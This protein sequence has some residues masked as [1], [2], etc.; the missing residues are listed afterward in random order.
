MAQNLKFKDWGSY[1]STQDNQYF[2]GYVQGYLFDKSVDK[3]LDLAGRTFSRILIDSNTEVHLES[4][5]KVFLQEGYQLSFMVDVQGGK[6]HLEL[7][8]DGIVVD[9]LDLDTSWTPLSD[10]T[11][12]YE[13]N[14]GYAKNIVSIAVHFKNI[15]GDSALVDGIW[16]I[17]DSPVCA[18]SFKEWG[19]Y[20]ASPLKFGSDFLGYTQGFLFNKSKDKKPINTIWHYILF[21]SASK[22]SVAIGGS[23]ILQEG[24]YLNVRSIDCET[25][26]VYLELTCH[27]QA[28]DGKTVSP[29]KPGATLSD[30]TYYF[31][32]NLGSAKSIVTIAVHFDKCNAGSVLVD[33]IWQISCGAI[34]PP[35]KHMTS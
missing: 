2:T 32:R 20:S 29:S 8:Q 31:K 4:G 25:G 1:S 22:Q 30:R 24:Y 28:L 33:G 27:G 11:Y 6:I 15:Y 5:Q 34:R 26:R 3:E 12:C 19:L 7:V 16:Q 13:Q 9:S 21:D 14:L 18:F 35:I 17:S 23:L 10:N